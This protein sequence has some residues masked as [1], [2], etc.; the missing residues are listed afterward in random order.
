MVGIDLTPKEVEML[1]DIV[2]RYLPDLRVEIADTDDKEFR[3][4]LEGRKDFMQELIQRLGKH[5]SA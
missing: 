5:I 2:A 3:R 4:F 1:R